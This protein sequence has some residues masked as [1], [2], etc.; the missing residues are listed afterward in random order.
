MLRLLQVRGGL[1]RL[2][3]QAKHRVGVHALGLRARRYLHKRASPIRRHLE[4]HC[5]QGYGVSDACHG[6]AV[7]P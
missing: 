5:A 4:R 2:Q 3:P 1:V 6:E 7:R